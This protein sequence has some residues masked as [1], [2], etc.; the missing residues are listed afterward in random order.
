MCAHPRRRRTAALLLALPA[1]LAAVGSWVAFGPSGQASRA[2]SPRG[3][4][5]TPSWTVTGLGDSVTAGA[6]CDC[7]DF[8]ARYAE[9]T[10]HSTGSE[11]SEHNLGVPGSTSADLVSLL[12]QPQTAS[13]VAGSDIVLVTIGANDLA[14]ELTDWQ[15]G[16]CPLS[17]FAQAMPAIQ[18]NIAELVHGVQRLRTGRP[19]EILVTDYWN[20]FLD[21]APAAPLGPSYH[22]ISDQVTRLANTAICAGANSSGATCVDLYADFKADGSA[23][24][25]PLLAVDGDHPDAAGHQVI[26]EALAAHG[27]A[28]LQQ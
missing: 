26:A 5:T 12:S 1:A 3:G 25:T 15:N 4:V 18:A 16:H 17:C 21:G 13:T 7:D 28:E 14:G 20:V 8:V 9:L 6:S 27:W 22:A 2:P 19:T 10:R 24:P 23:D 11:V